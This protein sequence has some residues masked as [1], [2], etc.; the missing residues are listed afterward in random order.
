MNRWTPEE[1]H[2]L[3]D[4]LGSG[5]SWEDCAAHYKTTVAA[6]KKALRRYK[7]GLFRGRTR[8]CMTSDQ[9]VRKIKKLLEE[10]SSVSDI[11]KEYKVHYGSAYRAARRVA[12]QYHLKIERGGTRDHKPEFDPAQHRA[13]R[14]RR[15]TFDLDDGKVYNP[16][17]GIWE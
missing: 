2:K 4:L 12:A 7:L 10:G 9:E 16:R 11:A 5:I 14:H 1:L 13:E 17:T 8:A 6:L 15:P 3:T